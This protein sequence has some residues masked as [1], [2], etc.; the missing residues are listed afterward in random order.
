MFVEMYS[1][2]LK[3]N[4]M[5]GRINPTSPLCILHA[6]CRKHIKLSF[7]DLSKEISV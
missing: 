6:L 1:L 7:L 5:D 4:Y 3:I 2:V